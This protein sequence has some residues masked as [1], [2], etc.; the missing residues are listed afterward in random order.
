M[1]MATLTVRNVPPDL[2]T[3]LKQSAAANRRS[4]NSEILTHLERGLR[5]RKVDP[6]ALLGHARDTRRATRRY[7][8]TEREFNAAKRAG[9]P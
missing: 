3:L 7:P 4:V 2:H 1:T 9:R 8:I 5:G 6:E